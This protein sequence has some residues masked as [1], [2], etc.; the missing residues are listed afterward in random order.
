GRLAGQKGVALPTAVAPWLMN[1]GAQLVIP[2]TGEPTYEAKWKDLAAKMK[3]GLA[4]TLGFDASLAQRIYAGADLFLIPSRFE[5]CGLG[6]LIS[7]RYGTIPV[8]R[9]VG[10]LATTVR[11]L[12]A[13]PRGNGFLF[14]KYEAV[15]FSDAIARALHRYRAGGEPWRQLRTRAMREDHSWPA[16]AK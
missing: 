3:G 2:G 9:A 7:L 4:L 12:D 10:G 16:A 6:Q 14:T 1:N 13:D 8:V 15:A 5:P 11:D